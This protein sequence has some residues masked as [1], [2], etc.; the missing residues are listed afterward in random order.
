MLSMD[1]PSSFLEIHHWEAQSVRIETIQI[2]PCLFIG[3]KL[4]C[5]VYS[6][7]LILWNKDTMDI[8]NSAL[9]LRG[10]GVDLA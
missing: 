4:I 3:S 10:F 8:N 9:Q 7:D 5:I 2:D 6:D 1:I